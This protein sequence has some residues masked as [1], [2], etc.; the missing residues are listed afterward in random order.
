MPRARHRYYP[1]GLYYFGIEYKIEDRFTKRIDL[2]T[3]HRTQSRGD[4]SAALRIND[5]GA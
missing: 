2:L 5:E 3:G 4:G 1:I